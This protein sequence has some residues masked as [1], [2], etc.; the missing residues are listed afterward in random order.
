MWVLEALVMLTK[1]HRMG[2]CESNDD[3]H[4]AS[5][6]H[7]RRRDGTPIGFHHVRG[8]YRPDKE[9]VSM[10]EVT[11]VTTNQISRP[12]TAGQGANVLIAG[13]RGSGSG[14][15]LAVPLLRPSAAARR[16]P[17]QCHF[18]H[19]RFSNRTRARMEVV[20]ENTARQKAPT[21]GRGC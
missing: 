8:Q 5:V 20:T 10:F 7:S 17:A 9:H 3:G 12:T 11:P 2:K 6:R 15:T 14:G 4:G 21:P 19:L 16:R 13:A 1:V 18:M